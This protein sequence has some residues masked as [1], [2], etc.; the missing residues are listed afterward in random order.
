M[1]IILLFLTYN[2]ETYQSLPD[3]A[4]HDSKKIVTVSNHYEVQLVFQQVV[5]L[6]TQL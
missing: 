2:K 1:Q 5:Q 3:E 4:L 6:D